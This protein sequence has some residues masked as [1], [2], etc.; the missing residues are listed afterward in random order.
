[1]SR[2]FNFQRFEAGRPLLEQLT[3]DR[4][5]A[6]LDGIS[7]NRP[8]FGDN[9]TGQRTP[10]GTI[11]RTNA[12]GDAGDS[13]P[14]TP[15]KVY[16]SFDNSTPPYPILKI[17]PGRIADIVPTLAAAK[18]DVS[19]TIVGLHPWFYSATGSYS[20][21]LK[22]VIDNTI[23]DS[24]FQSHVQSVSV[25]SDNDALVIPDIDPTAG[26]VIE[27]KM[28]WTGTTT[29]RVKGYFYLKI[30]DVTATTVDGNI[31]VQSITQWLDRSYRTF[32]LAGDEAIA[33]V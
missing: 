33:I 7:R 4:L 11:L 6:I 10:G 2:E 24:N 1:M 26:E 16:K 19:D 15:F 3:A 8:E 17:Y 14:N 25:L 31:I 5:N 30:A 18:L 21:F 20:L 22:V 27:S 28:K 29:D 32:V 23:P 12:R 13:A 9:I